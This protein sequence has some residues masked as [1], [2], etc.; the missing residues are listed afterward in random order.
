MLSSL[1]LIDRGPCKIEAMGAVDRHGKARFYRP[2]I[3]LQ[4]AYAWAS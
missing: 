4:K 3:P 2:G 1:T